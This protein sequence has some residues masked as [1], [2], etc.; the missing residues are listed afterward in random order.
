MINT[1]IE[2]A[3]SAKLG[4]EALADAGIVV[5]VHF[6]DPLVDMQPLG[7]LTFK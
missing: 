5:L 3:H 1:L 4:F 6:R 2:N 7:A